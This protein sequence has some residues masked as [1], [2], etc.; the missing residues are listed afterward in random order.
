MAQP[1]PDVTVI[2]GAYNAMPYLTRCIT[3]VM[4]QSI[5]IDRV[6][7]VAVDDG[8]TDT[9]GEELE[10]LTAEYRGRMTVLR[11][12]NS[13][14]PSAPRNAGLD[15]ARG[16]FV[17]FLD[18]DDY[19]GVEALERMVATA[20]QNSTDVVLGRMVGVG[21]R[22][23]PT[24]VFRRNQPRTSVLDSHAYT[25]LN[26]MKL[27]RREL[28]E[29]LGLRFPTDL[30]IGED[31]PFVATAYLH[32]RAISVVADYDCVYWV[33]RDDGANITSVVR[34]TESR[35]RMLTVMTELVNEH[36]EPGEQRD[37]LMRRHLTVDLR[38]VLRKLVRDPERDSREKALRQ[39]RDL[40]A[41][42][43]TEGL[44]ASLPAVYRLC[45]HLIERG[46]LDALVAVAR[47]RLD[48]ETTGG[49]LTTLV[50]YG[51]VYARYPHFREAAL[52]LPDHLFDITDEVRVKHRLVRCEVHDGSLHLAGWAHLSRVSTEDP[53]TTVVLREHKGRRREFRL[54]VEATETPNAPER[55]PSDGCDYS[56]AGFEVAIGSASAAAGRRLPDGRW[57][58]YLEVGAQGVTKEVRLGSRR[59]P[60]LATEPVTQVLP[61]G[62]DSGFA[63][64]AS[65]TPRGHLTLDVGE[66]KRPGPGPG[67][68]PGPER[69]A[70][71]GSLRAAKRLLRLGR[72][73]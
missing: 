44:V 36:T 46:E 61:D 29:R 59:L 28:I 49:P 69:G 66:E 34:D 41:V 9:T 45:W 3:S 17:F 16:R 5:G 40:R 35:L 33:A 62:P 38:V 7:I 42:S 8:S 13:G 10:R 55:D 65:Y 18:A 27:F 2:V 11:Q 6:E 37:L 63:V 73:R 43:A 71:S 68:G 24:R 54:P 67:P 58:V 70:L 25:T 12:E 51:R 48:R 64:T 47:D 57:D 52:D 4:Q 15:R 53:C 72:A 32:A 14:G 1:S 21:G 26:P 23:G 56:R 20:D 39:L 50:E 22:K 31:Q 30:R 60:E 19:L